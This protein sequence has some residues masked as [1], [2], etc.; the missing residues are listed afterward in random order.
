MQDRDQD[1][2]ENPTGP[3]KEEFEVD[4]ASVFGEPLMYD[5]DGKAIVVGTIIRCP[6]WHIRYRATTVVRVDSSSTML[7]LG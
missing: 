3:S 6:V 1:D 5:R 7:H 4:Y 2:A